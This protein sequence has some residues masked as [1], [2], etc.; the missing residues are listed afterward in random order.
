M[1]PESLAPCTALLTARQPLATACVIRNPAT[2]GVTP[3]GSWPAR[4]SCSPSFSFGLAPAKLFWGWCADAL[5]RTPPFG[6]DLLPCRRRACAADASGRR[7][8]VHSLHRHARRGCGIS[9]FA[10]APAR[11][12]G[13]V[14][15]ISSRRIRQM[16]S[17]ATHP[18]SPWRRRHQHVPRP[19]DHLPDSDFGPGFVEQHSDPRERIFRDAATA[20]SRRGGRF[21]LA[22]PVPLLSFLGIDTDSHGA[23]DWHLGP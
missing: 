8:Q 14:F 17:R 5:R 9:F 4:L 12:S 6:A 3:Y 21:L 23:S 22:R 16:D 10:A 1:S 15:R 19:A 7:S 11:R 18:L 13:G 20:R 2:R